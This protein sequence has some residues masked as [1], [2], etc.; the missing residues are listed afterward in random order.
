M[1]TDYELRGFY[2]PHF[3]SL[4]I[5]AEFYGELSDLS[6]TDLGTFVHEYVHYL[7]NVTTIFGLRNSLFYFNYLYEV[8]R[9]IVDNESLKIPL[10][11]IPHSEAINKGN[12]LFQLTYGTSRTFSPEYDRAE[13][14]IAKN[15][16]NNTVVENVCIDLFL[17]DSK[18]ETIIF[19]NKCVKESMAHL[20]QMLFD[21]NAKS[22]SFPYQSVEILCGLIY[23]ELLD[24]KRKLITLCLISLNSQNCGLILFQLLHKAKADK[25]LNGI[26]LYKKYSEELTV[27]NS[28][29]VITIKKFLIESLS[30]FEG[31]LSASLVTEVKHFKLLIENICL[32]AEKNILPLIEVI[33][34]EESSPIEK[35]QSLIDFYGI[36]HIR[37]QNGYN[38]Y[39]QDAD[40]EQPALEFVELIGQRIVLDRILGFGFNKN[41]NLCTL[42]SQCQLAEDDIT[43]DNCFDKQWER[44][45]DCPFK[46]VS[47]NWKLKEKIT[48]GD[49]L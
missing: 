46:V 32:S 29:K 26:D 47:D 44:E 20:Y 49:N 37:T 31:T 25:D 23:P 3:F 33:Y 19:G 9:Y 15:S 34:N 16:N 18:I 28:N 43:D 8:K 12:D 2:R 4:F 13:V 38:Y 48:A 7:Q 5:N 35:I 30:K 41:D 36:P 1:E 39:P 42:Y 6:Q 11:E 10:N 40:S 22:D 17:H 21:E 24:D 27:Y 45:K 14:Y